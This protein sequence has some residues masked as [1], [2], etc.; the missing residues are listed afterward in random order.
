MSRAWGT[1][2]PYGYVDPERD[3]RH[4]SQFFYNEQLNDSATYQMNLVPSVVFHYHIYHT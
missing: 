1:F 4:Q 3:N 2:K